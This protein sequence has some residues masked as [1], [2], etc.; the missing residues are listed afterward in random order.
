LSFVR[1][2]AVASAMPLYVSDFSKLFAG[3]YT[4][5]RG[6]LWAAEFAAP[7]SVACLFV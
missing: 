3:F 5:R 6:V 2:Q 4:V 7:A 1:E